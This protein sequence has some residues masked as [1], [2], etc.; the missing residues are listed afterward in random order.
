MCAPDVHEKSNARRTDNTGW[1]CR[2]SLGVAPLHGRCIRCRCPVAVLPPLRPLVMVSTGL[3]SYWL[4]GHCRRVKGEYTRCVASLRPAMGSIHW[5]LYGPLWPSLALSCAADTACLP[6]VAPV[7]WLLLLRLAAWLPAPL[8][9][10]LVRADAAPLRPF[11]VPL[12][13]SVLAP[14]TIPCCAWS[15]YRSC[16]CLSLLPHNSIA[17]VGVGCSSSRPCC[18][19]ALVLSPCPFCC[20]LSAHRLALRCSA[21][22]ALPNT[23]LLTM[24]SWLPLI[25]SP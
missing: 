2:P 5:L 6:P 20:S 21:A 10:L 14:R 4:P 1:G 11:L 19:A 8:L 15:G 3:V 23:T 12:S 25:V 7:A 24:G 13:P 17:A 16:P 9:L 18:P 22:C